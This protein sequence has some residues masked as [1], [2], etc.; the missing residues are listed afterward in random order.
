MINF[1]TTADNGTGEFLSSADL[2]IVKWDKQKSN[3]WVGGVNSERGSY[4]TEPVGI[5][6]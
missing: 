1:R 5:Q 4:L 2:K 3:P 6:V